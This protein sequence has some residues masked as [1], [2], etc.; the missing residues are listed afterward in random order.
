MLN[1]VASSPLIS[2]EDPEVTELAAAKI[3]KRAK[4]KLMKGGK[5]RATE[6]EVSGIIEE[7]KRE[8]SKKSKSTG[9]KSGSKMAGAALKK[10]Y[11][12]TAREG[13]SDRGY[14]GF[15]FCFNSSNSARVSIS[16][17]S[18]INSRCSSLNF[19]CASVN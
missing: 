1:E 15:F 2:E 9:A 12:T 4:E 14:L 7:T 3:V 13:R 11:P 6:R 19:L 10:I 17:P 8:K 18:P 5:P 16:K